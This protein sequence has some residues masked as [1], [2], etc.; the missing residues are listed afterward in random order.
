[1]GVTTKE[2]R[3]RD[4]IFALM[5]RTVNDSQGEGAT[6]TS[7]MFKSYLSYKQ[8]SEYLPLLIENGLVDEFPKHTIGNST[9]NVYRI[10]EKG[11]RLLQI[12]QE[13]ENLV[14]LDS[15]HK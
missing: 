11:L 9:Q 10:T 3:G 7:I 8:L 2:Y 12:S 5:L 13:I 4:E 15:N 6:K 14:G 1:M